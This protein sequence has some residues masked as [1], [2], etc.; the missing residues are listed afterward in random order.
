MSCVWGLSARDFDRA[1]DEGVVT[2]K[3]IDGVDVIEA[4]EGLAQGPR[5][6]AD[7]AA[8]PAT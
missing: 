5:T 4:G 2:Y 7:S 8:D 1:L 6:A 3:H